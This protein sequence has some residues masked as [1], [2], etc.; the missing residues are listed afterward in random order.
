MITTKSP[1][2]AR[3]H[4]GQ[5][6]GRPRR[7]GA[8]DLSGDRRALRGARRGRGQMAAG[9]GGGGLDGVA[10]G[11]RQGALARLRPRQ[12][13]L[14]VLGR[15]LPA[16]DPV[17]GRAEQARQPGDRALPEAG[18]PPVLVFDYEMVVDGRQ[19]ER[20][21]NYVLVRIKP[22][23]GETTRSE[24][25]AV[26]DRRPARRPRSRHRRHQGGEPGRRR[27]ARR[28]PGLLRRR[29]FPSPSPARPSRTSAA[30]EVAVRAEGAASCIPRPTASRW[31]SATAR[32]AGRS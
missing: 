27:A 13:R 5:R 22:E 19:L 15:C 21:V 31:W 18:K 3:R 8:R 17:L 11:D 23:A 25:A 14:G 32:P 2:K 1:R 20:P 7:A 24:E 26:R 9:A 12:R 29:S 4:E 16:H 10:R 6:A 30:A 28:P